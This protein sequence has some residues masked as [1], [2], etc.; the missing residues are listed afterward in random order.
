MVVVGRRGQNPVD[1]WA[2][3]VLGRWLYDW[4]A[5]TGVSQRRVAHLAGIDQGGLSRIEH[6]IG[7]PSGFRLAR[8]IITLDWLSGGGGPAG[9]WDGLDLE[10]PWRIGERGPRPPAVVGSAPPTAVDPD[11]RLLV[12]LHGPDPT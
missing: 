11:D 7:R 4:R 5:G 1:R 9:P 8:L 10:R 12:G 3:E 2:A 6:G